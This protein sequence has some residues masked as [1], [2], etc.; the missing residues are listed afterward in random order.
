MIS[1]K[2]IVIIGGTG[3]LGN[4]LT[5]HFGKDNDIFIY[6]RDELKQWEMRARFP[7]ATFCIGDIRSK[8]RMKNLLLRH[9]PDIIIIAC[10]MK[11]I[12]VCEKNITECINTNTTGT[13]NI[14][15]ILNENKEF[16]LKIED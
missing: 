8:E 2:K 7:N 6:S 12:D 14:L 16:S 5:S 9:M 10:A 11:H 3:S 4:E 13:A 15:S 1:G